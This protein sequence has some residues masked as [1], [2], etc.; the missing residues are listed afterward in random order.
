[1]QRNSL[2]LETPVII[3]GMFDY[4]RKRGGPW[5]DLKGNYDLQAELPNQPMLVEEALI[6][7]S[8]VPKDVRG[9]V[10]NRNVI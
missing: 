5:W 8:Q 10:P 1:M 7:M 6:P 4:N 9:M 2:S 3:T